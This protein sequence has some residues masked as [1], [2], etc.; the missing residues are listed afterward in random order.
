MVEPSPETTSISPSPAPFGRR[1]LAKLVD[2]LLVDAF[3]GV[4]LIIFAV[5]QADGVPGTR[6][7]FWLIGVFLLFDILYLAVGTSEERQTL[8]YRL[9]PCMGAT[10]YEAVSR[11]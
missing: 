11:L 8:G 9:P 1:F 10:R 6:L 2:L 5:L 3:C 4:L 7:V